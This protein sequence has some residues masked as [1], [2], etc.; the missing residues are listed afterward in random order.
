MSLL[1]KCHVSVRVDEN[2]GKADEMKRM[3]VFCVLYNPKIFKRTRLLRI[4][5]LQTI[6]YD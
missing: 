3:S 2:D 1:Y 5:I 6:R 4:Y